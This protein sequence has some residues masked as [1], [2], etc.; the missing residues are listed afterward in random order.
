MGKLLLQTLWIATITYNVTMMRSCIN[1]PPSEDPEKPAAPAK[2]AAMQSDN[3][4]DNTVDNSVDNSFEKAADNTI[5][6]LPRT[7]KEWKERLTDEQFYILRAKGTE[8]AFSGKYDT[9]FEE[10]IY[11]CAGCG[12]VIFSS[13]AKYDSGCGWP[14]FSAPADEK[15]VAARRDT[16]HGMIRT[17]IYC[18][19]C[20][21]HLGHVFR[22][23]PAPTGLRYCINSAALKFE[24]QEE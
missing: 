6:R 21:G 22:D 18:P 4:T 20:G 2:E 24:E 16:S 23:G 14:A 19:K 1:Q 10:G 7:E 5:E 12:N 17:E 13:D 8:P 3:T 11:K 9:F 15:A